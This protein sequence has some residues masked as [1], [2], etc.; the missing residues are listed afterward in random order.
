[1]AIAIPVL[2]TYSVV[3]AEPTCPL[4]H[5]RWTDYAAPTSVNLDW[6]RHDSREPASHWEDPSRHYLFRAFRLPVADANGS[7]LGRGRHPVARQHF[8]FR[9][10]LECRRPGR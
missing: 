2:S 7:H 6:W 3:Q 1:M 8:W 10:S 9:S 4:S 5:C